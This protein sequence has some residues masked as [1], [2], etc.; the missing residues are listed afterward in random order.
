MLR[1]V[2][3]Y[4]WRVLRAN[5]R[6]LHTSYR[7]NPLL[8]GYSPSNMDADRTLHAAYEDYVHTVSSPRATM[9]FELACVLLHTLQTVK[10]RV[11][12]DLGSG[13]SSYL[14]RRYQA[15]CDPSCMVYSC[16]DDLGWLGRTAAFLRTKALPVDGLLLWEQ[17]LAR[18]E[19]VV[20]GVLLH[21][22][23]HS[24]TRIREVGRVLQWCQQGT[25]VLLDDMHKPVV[26][27]AAVAEIR[28]RGLRGYDLA[29]ATLDVYGRFSWMVMP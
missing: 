21:D 14:L 19:S 15:D 28:R 26:Q 25:V 7:E 16:D 12:L 8:R 20:P 22:L 24:A 13:F 18:H 3:P 17:Y 4:R 10:P 11:A 29:W 2:V 27:R 1:R 5:R 9:S 23:G 6:E